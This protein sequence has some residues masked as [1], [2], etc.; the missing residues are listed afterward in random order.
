MNRLPQKKVVAGRRKS[1]V[2]WESSQNGYQ[3][4]EV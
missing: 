4:E 1:G 2:L 3:T